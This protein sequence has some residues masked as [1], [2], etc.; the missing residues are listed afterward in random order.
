MKRKKRAENIIS[1]I[2]AENFPGMMEEKKKIPQG[3]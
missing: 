3:P 2:M 1:E